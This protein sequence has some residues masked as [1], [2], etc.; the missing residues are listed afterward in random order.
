M[1][2]FLSSTKLQVNLPNYLLFKSPCFSIPLFSRII[3][4]WWWTLAICLLVSKSI[5]WMSKESRWYLFLMLNSFCLRWYLFCRNAFAMRLTLFLVCEFG[6]RKYLHTRVLVTDWIWAECWCEEA[7]RY[8]SCV[9]GFLSFCRLLSPSNVSVVL[10]F[11][12]TLATLP[13]LCTD[14]N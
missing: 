1:R 7:L 10:P 2:I 9:S 6:R 5:F 12:S 13:W 11:S 8:P 3:V 14:A 4:F